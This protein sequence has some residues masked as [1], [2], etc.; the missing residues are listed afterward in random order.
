MDEQRKLKR[1]ATMMAKNGW[2][3]AEYIDWHRRT[4]AKGG[5]RSHK[6]NFDDPSTAAEAVKKYWDKVRSSRTEPE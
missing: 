4:A 3:E 1:K 2:T 6:R 5:S